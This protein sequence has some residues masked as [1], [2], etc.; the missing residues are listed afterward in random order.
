MTMAETIDQLLPCSHN[1][2]TGKFLALSA[3]LGVELALRLVPWLRVVTI[4]VVWL[5]VGGGQPLG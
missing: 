4:V 2:L 5:D 3:L 1:F